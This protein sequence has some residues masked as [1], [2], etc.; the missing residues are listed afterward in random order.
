MSL[1]MFITLYFMYKEKKKAQ[2]K[3][4]ELYNKRDFF[5]LNRQC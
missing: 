2:R 3:A 5:D 4:N 1:V